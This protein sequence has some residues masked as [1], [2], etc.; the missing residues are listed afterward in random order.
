MA[1]NIGKSGENSD[2]YPVESLRARYNLLYILLMS[3]FGRSG[4]VQTKRCLLATTSRNYIL[5]PVILE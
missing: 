5:L 1:A 4:F 2:S 3:S